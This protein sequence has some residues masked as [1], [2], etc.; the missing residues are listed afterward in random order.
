MI[1]GLIALS[2]GLLVAVLAQFMFGIVTIENA[3]FE[4]PVLTVSLFAICATA[5]FGGAYIFSLGRRM[6]A[7][8]A[9]RI[10]RDRSTLPVLFLRS[11]GD[12]DLVDPTPRMIPMG[13]FFPRRYEESFERAL[14]PVGPL[15]AIGRPGSSVSE[16]GSGRFY[17]PDHAWRDAINFIRQRAVTVLFVVGRTEGLWW[18]I[19]TSLREVAP[20]RLLFF[21]PFVEQRHRRRSIWHRYLHCSPSRIP[22]SSA[23]YRRMEAER[24]ARYLAFKE[25]VQANLAAPLPDDLGEAQ[26]LDFKA[27]GDARLLKTIRPWWAPLAFYLPSARRMVIDVGETLR[28]FMEKLASLDR[29]DV[30]R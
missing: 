23:A 11:F 4:K 25:R 20:E 16:L 6:R 19:E 24:Q 27:T 29:R 21:F 12:D 13:D 2:I 22:F 8:P 17:V 28:P 30:D 7:V 18:E 3:L 26:F 1:A 10:L 5:L 14:R 15:V 9:D